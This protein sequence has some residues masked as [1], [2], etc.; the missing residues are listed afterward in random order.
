MQNR[1]LK[2]CIN[3]RD[4]WKK[5]K[6]ERAVKPQIVYDN[7][8]FKKIAQ[9]FTRRI[10][11]NDYEYGRKA[12]EL[13]K[14][15]VDADSKVL[16][17]GTGPGTLTV[18]LS[19]I[20]KEITGY[21]F[22]EI[23]I[24]NLEANLEE[25]NRKNV[26]IIKA[27]WNDVDGDKFKESFDLVVCSHFLWQMK[28]IEELLKRMEDASKKYC[29]VIQPCGRDNTVKEIFEIITDKE[30]T[31]QF[32][33]DADYFAYIILRQWGRLVSVSHFTYEY[34]RNLEE[35]IRYIAGFIGK[36]I[37]VTQAVEQRIGEYLVKENNESTNGLFSGE[38]KAAVMW[39]E[40]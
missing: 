24:K 34:S 39:W 27:N 23:N 37:E 21:D 40:G 19:G 38:N 17:I 22:S 3:W 35:E 13:L 8:F 1:K 11:L 26:K 2:Y 25:N 6:E 4:A 28:D 29:A 36:Y 30:Y 10:K 33:P 15:I 5:M 14:G 12:S 20:V 18:P 7:H 9:D 31:G 16:E 32:E